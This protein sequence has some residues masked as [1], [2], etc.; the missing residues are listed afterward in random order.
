VTERLDALPSTAHGALC[1]TAVTVTQLSERG[2]AY[3]TSEL[4]QIGD[5]ARQRRLAMHLDGA[6]FANAVAA[7][8]TT[9]ADMTWR[10]G[11]DVMSFGATKNGA[12]F[13]DAVV[14]FDTDRAIDFRQ[15]LKRSG[16]SM[17]KTRFMAAQ[18]LAYLKDDRWLKNA[19]HA[20][21]MASRVAQAILQI[22]GAR[23]T[24][25]VDGNMVFAAIPPDCVERL[26]TRGLK[27]RAKGV[28]EGAM[29]VFR[30]VTSFATTAEEVD[31]FARATSA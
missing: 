29:Q 16:H 31:N 10:C 17:S 5:I 24:A 8:R 9:P 2:T 27:L 4:G 18:L 1:A 30:L 25:R 21:A 3:S 13:A 7:A 28:D 14:F 11:V 26:A 22:P 12:M 6:R 20:N 19:G 23:I 15:R